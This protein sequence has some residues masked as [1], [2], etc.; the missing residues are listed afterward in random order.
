MDD[1]V[2]INDLSDAEV[3]VPSPKKQK[4]VP[5]SEPQALASSAEGAVPKTRNNAR[6]VRNQVKPAPKAEPEPKPQSEE[7]KPKAKAKAKSKA[8]AKAKS[9]PGSEEA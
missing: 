6:A 2:A 4:T 3:E 7:P 8:K 9:S 5:K 1:L